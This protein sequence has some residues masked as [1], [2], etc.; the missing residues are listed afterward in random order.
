MRSFPSGERREEEARRLGRR[1]QEE[2]QGALILSHFSSSLSRAACALSKGMRPPD[3]AEIAAR[4]QRCRERQSDLDAREARVLELESLECVARDLLCEHGKDMVIV[5]INKL[6]EV[7]PRNITLT[8]L[9]D[10]GGEDLVII[11]VQIA[12]ENGVEPPSLLEMS[13]DAIRACEG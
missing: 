7:F 4:E 10:I 6:R 13:A 8:N 9:H 2:T 12:A 5:I 3:E 1:A 11:L